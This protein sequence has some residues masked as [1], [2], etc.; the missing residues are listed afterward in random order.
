MWLW[1]Y[2]INGIP[3]KHVM[4]CIAMRRERVANYVDPRLT[5]QAYIVTYSKSAK[6]LP[7]QAIWPSVRGPELSHQK[8]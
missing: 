8:Y 1:A 6:P 3:F 4:P 2:Q 5:V 7:D